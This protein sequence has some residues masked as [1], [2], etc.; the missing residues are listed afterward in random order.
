MKQGKVSIVLAIFLAFALLFIAS[1]FISV[2]K[3]IKADTTWY[4]QTDMTEECKEKWC[5]WI[6]MPSIENSIEYYSIYGVREPDYQL[7]SYTYYT[8][9]GMCRALPNGC[10]D[11][12]INALETDP[13]ETQDIRGEHIRQY[14]VYSADL[15]LINTIDAVEKVGHGTIGSPTYY[16]VNQYDDGSYRFVA[17]VKTF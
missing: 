9:S 4:P 8:V 3:M 15:P 12:I 11:A 7:E 10:E 2:S 5:Y 6:L 14:S 16:Y 17:V 1:I 13:V